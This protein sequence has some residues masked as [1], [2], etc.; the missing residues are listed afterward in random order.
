MAWDLSFLQLGRNMLAPA[1][2]F[3]NLSSRTELLALPCC[4]PLRSYF[5]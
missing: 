2:H 5:N 4:L 3:H 1:N